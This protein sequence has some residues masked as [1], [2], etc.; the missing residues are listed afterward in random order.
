MVG[1]QDGARVQGRQSRVGPHH[2]EEV[3]LTGDERSV[4][5]L[6]LLIMPPTHAQPCLL[7]TFEVGLVFPIPCLGHGPI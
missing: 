6:P 1:P 3:N 4:Y 7:P 5:Y 2:V